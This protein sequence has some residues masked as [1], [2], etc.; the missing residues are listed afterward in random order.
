VNGVTYVVVAAYAADCPETAKQPIWLEASV[1]DGKLSLWLFHAKW[2]K[3]RTA[4]YVE[5]QNALISDC[6]ERF[7]AQASIETYDEV[8]K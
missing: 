3:E 5:I 4:R 2:H 1:E 7:G 6:R 8:I